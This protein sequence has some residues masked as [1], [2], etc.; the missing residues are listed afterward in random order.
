MQYH[1][2]HKL[3]IVVAHAKLTQRGF[4]HQSKYFGQQGI[5][6]THAVLHFLAVLGNADGK[7]RIFQLLHLGLKLVDAL[8]QGA[9]LT[10]VAVVGTA[11]DFFEKKTEHELSLSHKGQSLT[12]REHLGALR[13]GICGLRCTKPPKGKA[14]HLLKIRHNNNVGNVARQ[15][16]YLF[17]CLCRW[18]KSRIPACQQE[19]RLMPVRVATLA[20][21][22]SCPVSGQGPAGKTV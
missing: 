17:C 7:I 11:E 20:G 2:A 21:R 3:H 16:Y 22:S 14:R 1:T 6:I 12:L 8:H 10:Q 18:Q 13:C 9:K 4:A 5:K 15:N 19:C